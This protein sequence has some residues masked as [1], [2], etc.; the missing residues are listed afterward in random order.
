MSDP[1]TTS[2]QFEREVEAG[3]RFRFGSNWASFLQ[4]LNEERIAVAQE[5]LRDFLGDI[6]GQ[7]FIDVGSGSGLFSLV[8]RRLGARV[9]SFD[10][11][12]DSV[13]CT[14]ELKRRYF[15]DDPDWELLGQAS[16]LDGDFIDSLGQY[17]IVYS[18]GVL[19]H[20]GQMWQAIDNATRLV[21]PGGR[22][23]IMIYMDR[24]LTS[25]AWHAIKRT[26][27]SGPVG[28]AAVLGTMVPYYI[29]RGLIEDV[30]R[31]KNPRARYREYIKNRGMSKMHD[32]IDW[33]GGYPYEFATAE[34]LTAHLRPL[35]FELVRNDYQEYLFRRAE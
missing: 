9:T 10:F 25:R 28:K 6:E 11:D 1:D 5:S 14:A 3:E 19:H 17:D 24:G 33:L 22:F 35:G 32:W 4:V 23:Y 29:T 7:T 8:A 34:A 15:A 18:W 13:A 27:V 16:V 26:F 31:L 12:P 30:A 2:A 20:T 21:R